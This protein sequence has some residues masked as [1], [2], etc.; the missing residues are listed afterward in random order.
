MPPRPLACSTSALGKRLPVRE[1]DRHNLGPGAPRAGLENVMPE[2]PPRPAGA[3][4]VEPVRP[5][6]GLE[7][8]ARLAALALVALAVLPVV[9]RDA[10]TPAPHAVRPNVLLIS[11]DSLR[12][13]HV[14]SY[15]Y[16][17]PTSPAIDR[18][19]AEGALFENA[20]SPASWTTPAHM[21][22][23][24][25][26]APEV[27]RV[28]SFRRALKPSA[29]TLAEVL[30][31]DGYAT[32][33]FVSG[34]TVMASYG[35]AQGFEVFDESLAAPRADASHGVTSPG[36]VELVGRYLTAW[37]AGGRQ[38]PFFVFLHM[39]DVHYDYAPPPPY[40]RMF[41]P[42]YAG[43]L[44]AS[45]F[46]TNPRLQADMDP[47]DLQH[48]IA[49]YDGEIRYTDEH[50]ARI[51]DRL[52]R[53]RALDDTLVVVTSDH[54]DEFFEHGAKGHSKTLYDEIIRVPLVMRLPGRVV[55][56]QR[57][58]EQVRL[59][60]VAPTVLGLLGIAPPD[61]FGAPA[62]PL[63]YRPADLTPW[64]SGARAVESFPRLPAFSESTAFLGPKWSLRADGFKRMRFQSKLRRD[65]ALFDLRADP[66]E[67]RSLLPADPP[68]PI[69]AGL[70]AS[71][72]RWLA[73]ARS[74]PTR[75]VDTIPTKKHEARLRA[76]GYLQ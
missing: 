41:D 34:A 24:T 39:W 7:H 56:G 65:G 2:V 16:G 68:P 45:G 19:A 70:D 6:H 25:A 20:I 64:I 57:R 4:L 11:I 49:L 53:L 43:D 61:D 22:L 48:L 26:L 29:V 76:L 3:P 30:H 35:F 28:T 36:L 66:R 46:E 62:M 33:G 40:D 23:L 1:L 17:R 32:A 58:D 8:W 71:F 59:M 5:A 52:R 9:L 69:L 15:G 47:R 50:V 18:L 10:G 72:D 74:E 67:Q 51:V 31:G 42:H 54:G 55:P 13:D 14:S 73:L 21:T 38:R 37:D 12:A 60:D 63:P 75:A 27:H 44:D